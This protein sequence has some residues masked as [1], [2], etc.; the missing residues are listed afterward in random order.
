VVEMSGALN[1]VAVSLMKVANDV[2]FL[3]SGPRWGGGGGFFEGAVDCFDPGRG[4]SWP[5]WALP[6]F[7]EMRNG[8]AGRGPTVRQVA[9]RAPRPAAAAWGS[10]SC[11][12]T[13]PAAPSC[14]AR[15]TPRSARR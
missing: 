9:D 15:S 13:S 3:G 8:L 5:R 1:T 11:P 4:G 14:P 2:R 6:G 12:R 10:C 7:S